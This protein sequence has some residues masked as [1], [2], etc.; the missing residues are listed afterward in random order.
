MKKVWIYSLC[1][2]LF[3]TSGCTN[4]ANKLADVGATKQQ[5]LQE[6]H[7]QDLPYEI[8]W[9]FE[10]E[11][12]IQT[13]IFKD[14]NI[15]YFGTS[16]SISFKNYLYALDAT[17]QKPIWKKEV[18]CMNETSFCI[19][20]GVVYIDNELKY[21]AIDAQ[22]GETKWEYQCDQSTEN[23]WFYWHNPFVVNGVVYV[24]K[25]YPSPSYNDFPPN[26]SLDFLYAFKASTGE[27]QWVLDLE[28]YGLHDTPIYANN[29]LYFGTFYGYFYAVNPLTGEVFWKKKI[30]KYLPSKVV[31]FDSI[32]C[33]V[34]EQEVT[35]VHNTTYLYAMDAKTADIL[36]T[37]SPPPSYEMKDY[38]P[39]I[40]DGIVYIYCSTPNNM[41]SG[42]RLLYALDLYTG[43]ELWQ[44]ST[45]ALFNEN[46][47]IEDDVL[48]ITGSKFIA[49][50]KKT[51][52]ELWTFYI[53]NNSHLPTRTQGIQYPPCMSN[54]ILYFVGDD[55]TLYALRDQQLYKR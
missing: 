13:S 49:L 54:G 38:S 11:E 6:K 46:P 53:R 45:T 23:D 17:T 41:S 37:F 10:T 9:T 36:W 19:Q 4:K 18:P 34:G 5:Q 47:V 30:A 24:C 33:F 42:R 43:K 55:G 16:D 2:C 35:D 22:T 7:A 50:E 40:S 25:S 1:V 12:E 52:T 32:L 51:G 26:K 14:T 39:V 44:Y 20:E 48:Y 21:S 15:L 27:L 3:L 31:C 8:L 29:I 28:Y